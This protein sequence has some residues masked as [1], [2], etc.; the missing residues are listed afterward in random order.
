MQVSVNSHAGFVM[1]LY[2]RTRLMSGGGLVM[3]NK[4]LILDAKL[5]TSRL[6]AFIALLAL[7][8]CAAQY[9]GVGPSNPYGFFAELLHGLLSPIAI[10]LKFFDWLTNLVGQ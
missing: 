9:S 5:N 4:P 10:A 6:L 8:G 3:T 7:T 1:T 2:G